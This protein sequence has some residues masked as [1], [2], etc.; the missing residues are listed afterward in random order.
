M[1]SIGSLTA[2]LELESGAFIRNMERARTTLNQFSSRSQR[3]LRAVEQ[4]FNRFDRAV[5]NSLRNMLSF[6]AILGT[7]A[8]T[9]GLGLVVKRSIEAA[10]SIA[11]TADKIGVAT[12]ALQELRYAAELAGV[13]QN[14]LDMA[15][16]RFTRRAAEAA[17]GTG[18]AKDALATLGVQL[19]DSTGALRPTEALLSD[20]ADAFTRIENP[21][22][23]VRLAF[24][25]FDSEGVVMVNMLRNGAAA[26]EETRQQARDLGLVLEDDLLR[27]A[28]ATNDSITTLTRVLQTRFTRA[29]LESA[30]SIDEIVRAITQAMPHVAS[31]FAE[32]SKRAQTTIREIRGIK[33]AI[34]SVLNF[35][36]NP[37]SV[38]PLSDLEDRVRMINEQIIEV[39]NRIKSGAG[40]VGDQSLLQSLIDARRELL[41]IISERTAE[42]SGGLRI[43][44]NRGQRPEETLPP[45]TFPPPGTSTTAKKAGISDAEREA[46]AIQRVIEAL[47]FEQ[48]QLM[49]TERAQAQYNALKRAGIDASHEMAPAVMQAAEEVYNLGEA[50]RMLDEIISEDAAGLFGRELER[51]GE[52]ARTVSDEFARFGEITSSAFE[53]AILNGGKLKDVLGGLLQDF[54]RMGLRSA[55]NS[56]FGVIGG[57]LGFGGGGVSSALDSSIASNPDLF[58]FANGGSFR[59]G[60]AGGTDSQLVAFRATPGEM[61]DVRTPGQQRDSGG[62]APVYNIDARGADAGAVARIERVLAERDRTEAQR[63]RAT[64]IDAR[65]R[66]GPMERTFRGA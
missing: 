22:D 63:I 14:T 30:S 65:R 2:S 13:Q 58:G 25:L 24:K 48:Q 9:A 23:R 15:L 7:V 42:E 54:A 59:V 41:S 31:F 19:R 18:E 36:S 37:T 3:A 62:Y 60:G 49:R 20:V 55:S 40:S 34:E 10:D 29:I 8:G 12:G 16:Q 26:L 11:K 61:V 6:R 38:Q 47:E 52:E 4:S 46:Q 56:I 39:E 32:L 53:D 28:E 51:V 17:Q 57:F 5:T 43:T 44:V 45:I 35:F 21:A 1:A 50:S 33:N 64:T 66:L 27:N